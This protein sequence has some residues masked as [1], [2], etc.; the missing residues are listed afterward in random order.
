MQQ[1]IADSYKT[2]L[3]QEPVSLLTLGEFPSNTSVTEGGRVRPRA[4]SPA[5]PREKPGL[6]RGATDLSGWGLQR[7]RP[8]SYL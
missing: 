7:L 6:C 1:G 3:T 2:W 5:A 4:L 8:Q